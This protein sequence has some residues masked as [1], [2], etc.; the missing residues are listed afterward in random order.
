MLERVPILADIRLR[1]DDDVWRSRIADKDGTNLHLFDPI[2]PRLLPQGFELD[3][4]VPVASGLICFQA[5]V[6]EWLLTPAPVLVLSHLTGFHLRQQRMHFRLDIRVRVDVHIGEYSERCVA[7]D[8]SAGG[9]SVR[10][11]KPLARGDRVLLKFAFVGHRF[12]TM[13]EVRREAST[14]DPEVG[15]CFLKLEQSEEDILVRALFQEQLRRRR[16]GV[17]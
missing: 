2:G 10:V 1:R 11:Q 9:M 13:A 7:S 4:E 17:G 8:L 6:S 3:C 15:L 5:T 12:E 14:A 16:D